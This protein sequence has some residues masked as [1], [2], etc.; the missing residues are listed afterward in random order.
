MRIMKKADRVAM[1]SNKYLGSLGKSDSFFKRGFEKFVERCPGS[2]GTV[3][4]LL[5][6][7][8]K[9]AT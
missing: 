5:Y 6:T 4:P 1:F 2:K 9:Y 7:P 8:E 3:H